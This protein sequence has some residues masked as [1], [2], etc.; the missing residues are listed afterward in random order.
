MKNLIVIAATALIASASF[1]ADKPPVPVTL[2]IGE[3]RVILCQEDIRKVRAD[4]QQLASNNKTKIAPADFAKYESLDRRLDTQY[5]KAQA[6]GFTWDE[7]SKSL[8][9]FKNE[10]QFVSKVIVSA[11][12][13]PQNVSKPSQPR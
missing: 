11:F 5:T 3:L 4:I 7:C 9:A 6:G 13:A 12:T 2:P 8:D 10:Y 1:A